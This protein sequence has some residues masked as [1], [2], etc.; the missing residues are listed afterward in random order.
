M[1]LILTHNSFYSATDEE[2][3]KHGEK[4]N[5]IRVGYGSYSYDKTVF[6]VNEMFG[7]IWNDYPNIMEDEVEVRILTRDDSNW[8]ASTLVLEFVIPAEEFIRLRKANKISPFKL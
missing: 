6:R 1:K 5:G 7:W 2:I 3:M 8:V 4:Y